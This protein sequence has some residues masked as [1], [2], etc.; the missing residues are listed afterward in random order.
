MHESGR[1]DAADTE[2]DLLVRAKYLVRAYRR[3]IQV[4]DCMYGMFNASDAR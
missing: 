1:S 3:F 2:C 4:Y